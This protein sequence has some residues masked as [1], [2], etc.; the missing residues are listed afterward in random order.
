MLNHHEF[1]NETHMHYRSLTYTLLIL[2]VPLVLKLYSC[3]K[4]KGSQAEAWPMYPWPHRP[5]R[6]PALGQDIILQC[7]HTVSSLRDIVTL[8]SRGDLARRVLTPSWH[9]ISHVIST[10]K[11]RGTI[12]QLADSADIWHN[13]SV[14]W[15][16]SVLYIAL[17]LGNASLAL[18]LCCKDRKMLY[19]WHATE[20]F[21]NWPLIRIAL[22]NIMY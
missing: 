4:T 17:M 2:L 18:W 6:S 19:F 13:T 9:D 7:L 22:N 21:R 14:L 5:S 12:W 11:I 20:K 3:R 8:L 1:L 10:R 15:V 16:A